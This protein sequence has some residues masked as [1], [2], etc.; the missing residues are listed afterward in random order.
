MFDPKQMIHASCKIFKIHSF[1]KILFQ[2]INLNPSTLEQNESTSCKFIR[3]LAWTCHFFS[4]IVRKRAVPYDISWNGH[5]DQNGGRMS[6]RMPNRMRSSSRYSKTDIPEE[7]DDYYD[8]D[9]DDKDYEYADNRWIC[10]KSQYVVIAI[11]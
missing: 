5:L 7:D 2:S 6:S 10:P 1:L 8:E 9:D 4:F 11:Q 3:I